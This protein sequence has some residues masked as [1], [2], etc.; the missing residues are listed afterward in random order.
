MKKDG[1]GGRR[2]RSEGR[3]KDVEGKKEGRNN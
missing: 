2:G 1:V 3:R